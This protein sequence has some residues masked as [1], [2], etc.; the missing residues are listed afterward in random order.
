MDALSNLS[1]IRADVIEVWDSRTLT[2]RPIQDTIQ[3][4]IVGLAPAQLNSIELVA[5]AIGNDAGFFST[6]AEG[7]DVKAEIAYVD[8]QLALRDTAIASKASTTELVSQL[9]TRDTTIG[10]KS[11]KSYVDSEL[12]ALDGDIAGKVSIAEL[13]SQ[14]ATR[15]S[16][17]AG[18][19]SS[20]ELASQL[21]TRDTALASKTPISTTTAL[22]ARVTGVEQV[23]TATDS[24]HYLETG[25]DALV[26]RG[27]NEIAANF[28]GAGAG[29]LE[30]NALFYKDVTTFGTTTTPTLQTTLVKARNATGL[31]LTTSGGTTVLQSEENGDL[32]VPHDLQCSGEVAAGSMRANSFVHN[33]TLLSTQLAGKE[34]IFEAQSPLQKTFDT[35][36]D[37]GLRID[38]GADLEVTDLHLRGNLTLDG[39]MPSAFFR[40][41]KVNADTTVATSAGRNVFTVDRSNGDPVGRYKVD[42]GETHPR[43]TAYVYTIFVENE[44]NQSFCTA[45]IEGLA[46][47]FIRIAVKDEAG[48]LTNR[49]FHIMVL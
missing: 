44:T 15:D 23:V 5:A 21:A 7:L 20:V 27:T 31:V 22:D 25:E 13:A 49:A 40:A 30:G 29:A 36:G 45:T 47:T 39:S 33:G 43:S 10:T 32:V 11:D 2:Y 3:Q 35:E 41:G 19:A 17:L 16:L 24:Y 38:P 9:A 26:I 34:D 1:S 12:D 46:S 48:T 4:S 8:A 28:L 42:F 14:L 37:I 18:K 6:I